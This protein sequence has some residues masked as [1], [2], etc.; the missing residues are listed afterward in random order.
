MHLTSPA[1][2]A[3]PARSI[4]GRI[5]T[6]C[7]RLAEPTLW[8]Q[9][10]GDATRG[11]HNFTPDLIADF[12]AT[13]AV[14]RQQLSVPTLSPDGTPAYAV[15]ASQDPHY[16]SQGGDLAFFLRCIRN[17]DAEALH[18]Y[19]M[20][21][22]D[23]LVAWCSDFKRDLTTISLV[24]GRAL[25]GGFEMALASDHIIAEEQSSFGFP[26]I[27]FGLFPCTGAMGLVSARSNPHVAARMMTNKKVYT[28]AELFDM[29]LVD[30]V[31]PKGMGELAVERYIATH[32]KRRK[33]NLKV[34]QS[35][36]RMTRID[37]IEART[38]VDD[39]V[40]TAM[41]L[42]QG[43][44]RQLEMLIMMQQS[45]STSGVHKKVA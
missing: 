34:Q 13:L 18:A 38:V 10:A 39:W 30:E 29:G 31:C 1:A 24:Q 37:E 17:R 26:E 20:S 25:G 16:F 2:T 23:V 7:R 43:E 27:L 41:A 6:E 5:S 28:A 42:D 14:T 21:C 32:S 15:I 11:V 33:A 12:K 35:R 36:H 9:I 19:S 3:L 22:L 4:T 44:L 8:I 45:E 40:E